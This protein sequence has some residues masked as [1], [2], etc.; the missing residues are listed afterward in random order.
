V[1]VGTRRWSRSQS[2]VRR[3]GQI[4]GAFRNSII[5]SLAFGV[6]VTIAIALVAKPLIRIWAGPAAVPDAKL[7]L[8][9]TLYTLIGL[10]MLSVVVLLCGLER[11]DV[12]AYSLSLCAI[13]TVGAG[14]VFARWWGLSGVGLAMVLGRFCAASP[15]QMYKVRGVLHANRTPIVVADGRSVV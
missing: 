12:L 6:P 4:G 1:A 13:F 2:W 15:I 9:L 8:W 14:I 10:A 7:I 11:A 3:F 5:A